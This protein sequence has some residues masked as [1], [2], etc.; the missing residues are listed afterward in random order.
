MKKIRV[1]WISISLLFCVGHSNPQ[2]PIEALPVI[3]V[4]FPYQKEDY[5][6]LT[7]SERIELQE[8]LLGDA[9]S[10]WSLADQL[11]H[12]KE[13][14][15][16]FYWYVQLSKKGDANALNNVGF[17]LKTGMGCK[18]DLQKSVAFFKQ[19]IASF[20]PLPIS[21]FSLAAME[22]GGKGTIQD[23]EAA[24]AHFRD[25]VRTVPR[26]TFLFDVMEK[27]M[28]DQNFLPWLLQGNWSITKEVSE[29]R[30]QHAFEIFA[31]V[32]DRR[33]E[34]ENKFLQWICDYMDGVTNMDQIC[35]LVKRAYKM[36]DHPA[37]RAGTL[38]KLK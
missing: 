6:G 19:S 36:M 9:K 11:F 16:S 34:V 28:Q 26:V 4:P 30:L 24:F 21:F 35:T 38:P 31:K 15:K 8:A 37:F 22:M 12:K 32:L 18:Q 14:E 20:V 3:E 7:R 2:S 17:F 29:E 27:V 10:Q 5:F 23:K 33:E 13:F 25:G 1:Y